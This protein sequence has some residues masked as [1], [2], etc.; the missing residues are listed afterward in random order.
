MKP[1]TG[2]RKSDFER[3]QF[4]RWVLFLIV[5]ARAAGVQ[6]I[7][8]ERLHALLF[9]S[10]ASSLFYG[11]PPLRQRAQRTLHGPYYRA[12]HIAVGQ[13]AL[14]GLVVISN[15]RPLDHKSG[16][17]FDGE[18]SPSIMGLEVASKLRETGYGE[19]IYR[20]LLDLCTSMMLAVTKDTSDSQAP[21]MNF[22]EAEAAHAAAQRKIDEVLS[23]DLSYR[24]ASARNELI[25]RTTLGPDDMPLTLIGLR[26]IEA[27]VADGRIRNRR[28]VLTAY[29]Y[30]LRRR[31]A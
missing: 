29:Q 25:L 14:S 21:V 8:R 28:D 15:Y 13:L 6:K 16:L 1:A 9:Q 31:A 10:F 17:L 7:D 30:L 24:Q 3:L 27:A 11:I 19:R 4:A 22:G 5:T 20:F 26:D 23:L 2:P 18:L 12:A